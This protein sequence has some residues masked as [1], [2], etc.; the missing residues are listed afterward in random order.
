MS[1]VTVQGKSASV[2][3]FINVGPEDP[4]VLSHP[5]QGTLGSAFNLPRTSEHDCPLPGQ[6]RPPSIDSTGEGDMS[7]D[8]DFERSDP[9][10]RYRHAS[11]KN[12]SRPHIRGGELSLPSRALPSRTPT[13]SSLSSMSSA[14]SRSVN[15][16]TIEVPQQPL[17]LAEP[18]I[19]RPISIATRGRIQSL[20]SR[21]VMSMNSRQRSSDKLNSSASTS[22]YTLIVV[23]TTGCGKSTMIKNG[24][25]GRLQG[26][27]T[28]CIISL[29]CL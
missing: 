15:S 19:S 3:H 10:E 21:S 23:G 4:S 24:I 26:T 25:R 27:F 14:T 11:L 16:G 20:Q 29:N 28:R 2:D 12:S 18:S 13:L 8:S 7:V 17:A 6:T 5:N 1:F 9:N 22:P